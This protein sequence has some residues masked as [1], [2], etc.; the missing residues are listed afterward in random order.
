M[1]LIVTLDE[2]RF[3][4]QVTMLLGASVFRYRIL[5]IPQVEESTCSRKA[6]R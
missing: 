6:L 5:S 2:G 1:D 4:P 3:Q